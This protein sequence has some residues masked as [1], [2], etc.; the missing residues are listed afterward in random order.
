MK[1]IK[2]GVMGG[3]F[4]PPHNGHLTAA[5]NARAALGLDRVLFIPTNIPPHKQ[6]PAGSATTA[7]RCEM[8]RRMTAPYPWAD[9]S[10]LE[11]ARGGASYT[12]DTLR[13]LHAQG[14]AD[15]TLI[16]GTD[17][18]LSFDRVWRA[19]EE[20]A[21]L[22]D[23][24]VVARGADDRPDLARKAETL[25]RRYGAR[26]HLV[27]GPV[28]EVSSTELREGGSIARLTPPA[29]AA[30]ILENRLYQHC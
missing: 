19:P 16:V 14:C 30:Y 15:L 13:Q 3:T 4:N 23:L 11:V 8:V 22:A 17:M 2:T 27:E 6:L 28:L 20:I 26:I 5:M 9:F 12:V 7:Q 1:P 21:R 29:V 25:R 18:L 10:D 24:A